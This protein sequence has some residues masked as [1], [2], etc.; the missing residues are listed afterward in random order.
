M[1]AM[2]MGPMLVFICIASV[3]SVKLFM[4]LCGMLCLIAIAMPAC[5]SLAVFLWYVLYV[6]SFS[7]VLFVRPVEFKRYIS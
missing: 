3:S 4:S 6:K 2:I 1:V 5:C 7:G